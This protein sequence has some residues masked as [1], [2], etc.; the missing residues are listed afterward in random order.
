MKNIFAI[1]L[2]IFILLPNDSYPQEPPFSGDYSMITPFIGFGGTVKPKRGLVLLGIDYGKHSDN[3]LYK[4]NIQT[5]GEFVLFSD[6][7]PDIRIQSL[8]LMIGKYKT[9]K[10]FEVSSSIGLGIVTGSKRGKY[11][12]TKKVPDSIPSQLKYYEKDS[13][14]NLSLPINF[15]ATFNLFWYVG[16]TA[17]YNLNINSELIFHY[18]LLGINVNIL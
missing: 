11:L 5:F 15:G 9:W 16:V 7:K 12:Y 18:F 10:L 6:E 4:V 8:N 17:N 2:F 13:F 3:T 14:T 1:F